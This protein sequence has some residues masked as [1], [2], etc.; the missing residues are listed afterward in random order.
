MR[1]LVFWS[2]S[3]SLPEVRLQPCWDL[4]WGNLQK[5]PSGASWQDRRLAIVHARPVFSN[6]QRFVVVGD[7]WL[8]NRMSL[9]HR[10]G[11]ETVADIQL[12]GGAVVGTFGVGVP[13]ATGGNVCAGDLR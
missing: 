4:A 3:P 12:V 11:I 9:L 7:V 2:R 8:S 1:F 10:L 5:L 6:S 13:I